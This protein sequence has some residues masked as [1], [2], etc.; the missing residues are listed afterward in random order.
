MW[1]APGLKPRFRED[2]LDLNHL[3]GSYVERAGPE[4]GLPE[5]SPVSVRS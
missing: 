2:R 5:R 3:P 4:T 1:N